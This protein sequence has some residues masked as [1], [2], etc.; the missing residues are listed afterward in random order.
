MDLN[1]GVNVFCTDGDGGRLEKVVVDPK[2]KEITH[3]IVSRGLLATRHI[4]VPRAF[5]AESRHDGVWLNLNASDLE[6]LPDVLETELIAPTEGWLPPSG[7][8]EGEV[9]WW[10]TNPTISSGPPFMMPYGVT[11]EPLLVEE[12]VN[13]PSGSV[14]LTE[15]TV[16]EAIDGRIGRIDELIFDPATQRATHIV[17]KRGGLFAEDVVIPVEMVAEVTPERVLVKATREDLAKLPSHVR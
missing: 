11:S 13:T 2:T 10:G 15:G 12:W 8:K 4:V 9:V 5:V 14:S 3:L 7:L 16:V 6:K 1:I 17:V